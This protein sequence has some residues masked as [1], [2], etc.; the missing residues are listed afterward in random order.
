MV[1][2][3]DGVA[4]MKMSNQGPGL[5]KDFHVNSLA[6]GRLLF[7]IRKVIFK[8]TLV[9]GGWCISYE[10]ALRWM[11]QGLTDDKSTL[12]QVVAWCRPSGNKPLPE[13]KLTQIYVAKWRH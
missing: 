1:E 13:P 7:N 9:N 5:L 11:Q 8:L 3:T 6:P 4:K 2:W 12:V 10:I